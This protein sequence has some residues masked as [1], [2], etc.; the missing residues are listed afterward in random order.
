MAKSSKQSR[1][2]SKGRGAKVAKGPAPLLTE[3]LTIDQHDF[4]PPQEDFK[5]HKM[6]MFNQGPDDEYGF[7]FGAG[8]AARILAGIAEYGVQ[9]VVRELAKV[10]GDKLAPIH[11][12][13]LADYLND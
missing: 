10:A 1:K 2:G 11:R 7:R 6:I 12:E 4:M 9:H 8:N 3:K 5:G 13:Q